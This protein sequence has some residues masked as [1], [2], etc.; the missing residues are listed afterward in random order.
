MS[1][2]STCYGSNVLL[3]PFF[4]VRPAWCN[5]SM[6]SAPAHVDLKLKS[7]H[8]HSFEPKQ[9]TGI[10]SDDMFQLGAFV[11]FF[12]AD[13]A[14]FSEHD[15][16]KTLSNYNAN[17]I[18]FRLISLLIVIAYIAHPFFSDRCIRYCRANIYWLTFNN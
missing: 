6:I 11:G 18:S 10:E 5:A 12:Y 3:L 13:E 2:I 15:V 7:R 1:D 9:W 16:R 17:T 14:V 4:F 8:A